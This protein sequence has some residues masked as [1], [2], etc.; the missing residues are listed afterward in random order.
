MLFL[1]CRLPELCDQL[2]VPADI[3]LG[4]QGPHLAL[5]AL[6]LAAPGA[7]AWTWNKAGAAVI[8]YLEQRTSTAVNETQGEDVDDATAVG[9]GDN[10]VGDIGVDPEVP[11]IKLAYSLLPLVWAGTLAHYEDLMMNELGLLLP[12]L[13]TSLGVD[14][15]ADWLNM[16]PVIGP[17]PAAVVSA[18]QGVTLVVGVVLSWALAGRIAEVEVGRQQAGEVTAVQRALILATAAELWHLIV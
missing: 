5:S 10:Q 17:A 4:Q 15:T 7:V 14:G 2:G 8:E 3:L 12:R 18:A 13:A 11:Y 1:P 9:N 6:L 16:L